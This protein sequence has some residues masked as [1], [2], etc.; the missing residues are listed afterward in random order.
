MTMQAIIP[1]TIQGALV[2]SLIDFVASFIIISGIGAVLALFPLLNRIG[3]H[4]EA[5]APVAVPRPAPAVP[6]PVADEIPIAVIAAAVH[7][8]LAGAHRIVHI[9]PTHAGEGWVAEGRAAQHSSHGRTGG[10]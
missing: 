6:A 2:L 9:Q 4:Q 7:A 5:P 1:D 8:T 3:R 10:R